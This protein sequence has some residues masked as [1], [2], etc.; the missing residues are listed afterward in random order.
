MLLV[1]PRS[2]TWA[3]I[4]IDRE[5]FDPKNAVKR[6]NLHLVATYVECQSI[7]MVM[8]KKEG[9]TWMVRVRRPQAE[10]AARQR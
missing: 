7:F 10:G 9:S 2:K 1:E 4:H 6:K 3:E 5:V 8:E